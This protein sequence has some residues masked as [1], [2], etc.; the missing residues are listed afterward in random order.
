MQRKDEILAKKAKLAELRR[1][2]EEREHRQKEGKRDS[3]LDDG[4]SIK[5]PT[6]RRSTDRQELDSFIETLVGERP[7][8]RGPG[9]GTT[10][11][12]VKKSRPSSTLGTVQ[13]G[14]ETYEQAQASSSKFNYTT[15]STQTRDVATGQENQSTIPVPTKPNIEIYHKAVQTSGEWY[16]QDQRPPSSAD[17]TTDDQRSSTQPLQKLRRLSR[18]QKER[19]EELRHNLRA[20]IEEELKAAR[21]LSLDGQTLSAPSKFPARALTNEELSAV[22]SSNEFLDFVERSSKVIEK[23]LDQDYDVLADYALDGVEAVDEDD[24]EGY[25]TTR[26][27]KSRRIRQVAQFWDEKG[28]KKR[29]TSDL[30]FSPK[31]PELLLAA[32]TKNPSTPQEPSGLLQVWN[33][34]L[35]SRPEYTFQ[36]TSDILTAQFSPFH[37]SLIIGGSYTGQ[38]LLWDT[39]SRNRLPVQ[40]TPLTGASSGGHTH[41]IYSISIVGTQNANNIISCSTDGVVCGWTTDMLTVPQEYL[42][43]TTPPPSKTEDLSPTCMSFP[44]SDPTSFLVGTEEGT[45]YPCHRYDRAGAKAG[46]DQRLRYQAHTAPVMSLN[47][48]PARGPVDLGDL[49]LSSALD[50]TVKIWKTKPASSTSVTAAPAPAYNNPTANKEQIVEPLIDLSRDDIVYDARWSPHKPGVFSVVD[51]AGNVEVWDLTIDTE[52]PISKATPQIDRDVHGNFVA[53]SLN[54]VVWEEK[55]G[56]RLAVGGAAGIVSVFE[57]GSDLAGES[58]KNDE[59]ARTKRLMARLEAGR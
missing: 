32:Y 6:P 55:E 47:F 18:R 17:S 34:H 21:D 41:P 52:V 3:L 9:T 28:S 50:W 44:I 37:P 57:V 43:L 5:V 56:K 54:K 13:V 29:M 1:Q 14:S 15:A 39:R 22:T 25:G 19:E 12:A 20:E 26:G 4:S 51:G 45:I 30:S 23:A 42:E 31:F 38:V 48:H 27:G 7:G 36:N 58:V 46:V 8:S 11:P 24:N 2:R 10:S 49:V 40:K 35:H 53:K 16:A 33:M 59:W